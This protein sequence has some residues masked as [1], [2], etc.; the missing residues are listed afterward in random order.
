MDFAQLAATSKGPG[1][2]KPIHV[3]SVAP[4][5]AAHIQH[6]ADDGPG[7]ET[8]VQGWSVDRMEDIIF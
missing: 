4:P 1:I 8:A 6:P 7:D 3:C 2:Y 5:P